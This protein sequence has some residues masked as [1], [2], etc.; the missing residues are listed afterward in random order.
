M[1]YQNWQQVEFSF[2]FENT[3]IPK[4]NLIPVQ[5]WSRGETFLTRDNEILLVIWKFQSI[6][7]NPYSEVFTLVPRTGNACLSPLSVAKKKKKKGWLWGQHPVTLCNSQLC[8]L[9]GQLRA[10]NKGFRQLLLNYMHHP[11]PRGLEIIK[12]LW[13]QLL[14]M[15]SGSSFLRKKRKKRQKEAHGWHGTRRQLKCGFT[16]KKNY[17]S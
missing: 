3:T 15:C 4:P 14:R 12:M 5:Y 17:N 7:A 1:T 10:K 9:T 8:S 13:L 2:T 11:G 6:E 16:F